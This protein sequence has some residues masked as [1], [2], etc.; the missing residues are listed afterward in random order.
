MKYAIKIKGKIKIF[1]KLPKQ[2]QNVINLDKLSEQKLNDLGFFK[3]LYPQINETQKQG[4]IYYKESINAYTFEI[5]N[6]TPKQIQANN[7]AKQQA[8]IDQL[9]EKFKRDGIAYQREM[10]NR[11]TAQ[12]VGRADAVPIMR[13]IN[14]TVYVL[15]NKI[16]AG[17]WVLAMLDYMDDDNNPTIQEVVDLF[18]EVGQ[19]ATQ[20]YQ[21]EYPH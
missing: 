5:V 19:K 1:N 15:L 6:L 17:D 12:L 11:V 9:N 13:E 4:D 20:Y 8:Y 2:W 10:K 21:D 14:N 7:Q 18:N 3:V 16:A